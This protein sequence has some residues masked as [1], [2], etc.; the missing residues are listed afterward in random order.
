MSGHDAVNGG[1]GLVLLPSVLTVN[2]LNEVAD[3]AEESVYTGSGFFGEKGVE[4]NDC[5]FNGVLCGCAEL[6]FEELFGSLTGGGAQLF[7]VGGKSAYEEGAVGQSGVG[8]NNLNACGGGALNGFDGRILIQGSDGD[9]V[10]LVLN[11]GV[12]GLGFFCLILIA[13]ELSVVCTGLGC[14]GLIAR[15]Y[16]THE[17]ILEIDH[18]GHLDLCAVGTC[19]GVVG[20]SA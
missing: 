3:F 13:V 4:A 17:L 11:I 15:A 18:A 8:K 1:N 6:F 7:L 20:L 12:N 10:D 2:N 9:T 14:C 5:D 16:H 19:S